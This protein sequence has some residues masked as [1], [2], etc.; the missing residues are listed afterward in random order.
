MA[1][2]TPPAG[3]PVLRPFPSS[4]RAAAITP[5]EPAGARVARFPTAG[6]LPRLPGGSAS[7]SSCFEA[8][9]AFTRVA[10]RVVAEPPKAALGHRSASADVVTF[11]VRSDCFRLERQ[12]PGGIRTRWEMAPCH[13]AP[14]DPI[15][16]R[17][18]RRSRP[19]RPRPRAGPPA[20]PKPAGEPRP[21]CGRCVGQAR[22]AAGRHPRRRA[23]RR[24][25]R[26]GPHS[27]SSDG[28]SQE[29]TT[30]RWPETSKTPS[31]TENLP[32]PWPQPSWRSTTAPRTAARAHL[33][34]AEVGSQVAEV[35]VVHD[36][37][38]RPDGGK[39]RT[40][41]HHG[42]PQGRDSVTGPS[43]VDIDSDAVTADTASAGSSLAARSAA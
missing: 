27:A 41:D 1:R 13:G 17:R 10:A 38:I 21:R 14:E 42:T 4:T 15:M 43:R 16:G 28:A 25:A 24:G 34:G 26:R 5:A 20:G 3:L 9:S 8:C 18:L 40:G 2:A 39:Q 36:G 37:N 23:R 30:C 7:A 32:A 12:L 31:A 11:I 19:V 35:E 6:S 29:S 33:T 22:A